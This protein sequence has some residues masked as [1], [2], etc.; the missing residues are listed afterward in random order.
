M[1]LGV[2]TLG[3]KQGRLPQQIP[4]VLALIN[5]TKGF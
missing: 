5:V 2:M 1:A 3:R 4:F